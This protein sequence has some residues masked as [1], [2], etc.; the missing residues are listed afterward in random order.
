[1]GTGKSTIGKELANYLGMKFLD[2]DQSIE[3]SEGKSINDIFDNQGEA[4]FRLLEHKTIKIITNKNNHIISTGGGLPCFHNNM[5][6]ML[7]KGTVIY[8]QK[9]PTKIAERLFGQTDDRPL[10]N[11]IKQKELLSFIKKQLGHRRRDYCKA[12]IT[13]RTCNSVEQI[14]KRII[15]RIN[16]IIKQTDEKSNYN[17]N[18]KLISRF[19]S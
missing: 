14:V 12:T 4:Y 15:F 1:M 17:D 13:V 7:E 5:D 19:S 16:K 3:Q 2:T 11:K 10:I 6:I 18:T 8:L 9:S